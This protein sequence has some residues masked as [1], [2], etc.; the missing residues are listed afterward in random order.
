[1]AEGVEATIGAGCSLGTARSFA[2]LAG[3]S[4]V[5]GV[6]LDGGLALVVGL[7]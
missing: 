2:G 6:A 7:R 1:V 4:F 3:D 5:G